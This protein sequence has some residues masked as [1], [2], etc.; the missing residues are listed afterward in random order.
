MYLKKRK[1]TFY[2]L[3]ILIILVFMNPVSDLLPNYT[4]II[5]FSLWFLFNLKNTAIIRNGL[6][7]TFINIII[8][9]FT[10][11]R[12]AAAG[13]L[14]TDYYS[15][16]QIVISRYQMFVYPFIFMYVIKL[17][18]E[19]KRKLFNLSIFCI[20][21]TV[22]FSLYYIFFIDPQAVRNTQREIELYGV[23]DFML[24]YSLAISSGPIIYFIN[25]KR[26][27]NQNTMIYYICF[28]LIIMCILFC[29]LVTS[30]IICALSIFIMSIVHKNNKIHLLFSSIIVF[31]L[32]ALKGM[33]A[34]VLYFV[35]NK[36]F[37]YW[38]TNN[39]IL[40]IANILEGDYTNID[41]LSRRFMLAGRSLKSFKEHPL[42]GI[43][44]NRHEY[45]TIGCHMQW[46][47]DL[48]R[49]GVLGNI[50]IYLNYIYLARVSVN[51]MSSNFNRNCMITIWIMFFI[52]GFLNPCISSTNLM[53]IFV[54]IPSM[55]GFF[56][57]DQ[58]GNNEKKSFS[59]KSVQ[60]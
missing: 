49:Y 21:I 58:R 55:E 16:F 19:E 32:I 3:E 17:H 24:I 35:A 15:S 20:T 22:L 4:Q 48:G 56:T 41:T 38:S 2:L 8:F 43:N 45:G 18:A 11:V 25:R 23:G 51:S 47:D 1:P 30:V 52:L 42:L 6:S 39:K 57:I 53:M 27:L 50:I 37:F 28:I 36:N 59:S 34:N 13:Q 7:Y 12:C 29:N 31:L 44:W 46:A 10:F 5:V 54:V 60:Q 26:Y 14:N 33:L 40:A 9:I